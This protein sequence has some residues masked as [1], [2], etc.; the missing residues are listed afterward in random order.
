MPWDFKQALNFNLSHLDNCT[1]KSKMLH[2]N[3]IAKG[4][5][6]TKHRSLS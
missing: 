6:T 2:N 1:N 3:K 4:I 5:I